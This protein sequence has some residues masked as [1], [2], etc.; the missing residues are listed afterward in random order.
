MGRNH[1]ILLD[2]TEKLSTLCHEASHASYDHRLT[3]GI[4]ES[5]LECQADAYAICLESHL[6]IEQNDIRKSHFS[7]HFK[8]CAGLENFTADS[9][10]K[11]VGDKFMQEWE[12]IEPYMAPVMNQNPEPVPDFTQTME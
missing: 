5:V 2:D 1:S 8:A 11:N 3:K 10:L 4:P 9:L 6:G 7:D 12:N